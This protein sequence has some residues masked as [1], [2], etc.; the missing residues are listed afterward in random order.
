[1]R[2]FYL[3]PD[4]QLHK[5]VALFRGGEY[6]TVEDEDGDEDLEQGVADVCTAYGTEYDNGTV[7]VQ[8]IDGAFLPTSYAARAHVSEATEATAIFLDE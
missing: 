3:V 8:F 4:D 7:S 1:M 2:R 6:F 5:I